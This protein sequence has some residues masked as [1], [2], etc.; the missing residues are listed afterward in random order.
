MLPHAVGFSRK[1]PPWPPEAKGLINVFLNPAIFFAAS[2][3]L[4]PFINPLYQDFREK[5]RSLSIF[6]APF[7]IFINCR[8]SPLKQGM[9]ASCPVHPWFGSPGIK[10]A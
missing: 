1:A 7:P 2:I 10:I 5:Q 3:I 8:F 6:F 9:T 4:H